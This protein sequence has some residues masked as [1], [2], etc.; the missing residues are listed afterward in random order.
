MTALRKLWRHSLLRLWLPLVGWM[1][2]IF[3]LSAQPDLPQPESGCLDLLISNG[4]H[5]F[6]FGVLAFLWARALGERPHG[7][8][9]A[10]A[11]S[12]VFALSD[13]FHQSFVPGRCADPLDLVWDALGAAL[14]LGFVA[15][16]R[17]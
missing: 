15:W 14:A 4:A 17:R 5:I 7:L 8:L 12:L 11:L 2:L 13:E 1:A 3:L 9:L 6:V 16:R 10:F